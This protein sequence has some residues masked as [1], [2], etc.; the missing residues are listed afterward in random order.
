MSFIDELTQAFGGDAGLEG[1]LA[2]V[3]FGCCVIGGIIIVI[4]LLFFYCNDE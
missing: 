4:Y 1:L 2:P 3:W